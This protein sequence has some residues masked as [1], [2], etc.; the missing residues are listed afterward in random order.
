M[1]STDNPILNSPFRE[2]DRHWLLDEN[3]A[4][5]QIVNQGRRRSEYLVPIAQPKKATQQTSLD[6]EA[7]DAGGVAFTSN[8]LINEIR[9][10]MAR[11]RALPPSQGG[12]DARDGAPARSLA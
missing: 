2:P 7:R 11:W 5:T 4:P 1:S 10:H 3:G 9:G 6:L 8:E 12:R